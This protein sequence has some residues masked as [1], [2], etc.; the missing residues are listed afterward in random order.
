MI[1][2][3]WMPIYLQVSGHGTMMA[4]LGLTEDITSIMENSLPKKQ[5][6]KFRLLKPFLAFFHKVFKKNF[7]Y[8]FLFV[9]FGVG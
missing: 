2:V 5:E 9:V 6:E 4:I 3:P 1:Y 7:L 8:P